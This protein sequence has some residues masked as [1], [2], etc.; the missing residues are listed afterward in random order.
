MAVS[1]S[2]RM[3]EPLVTVIN[4]PAADAGLSMAILGDIAHATR[5]TH[6]K[7]PIRPSGVG[8]RPI[9]GYW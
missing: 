1:R 3:A 7:W 4:G 6:F 9:S 2:A 8:E 5:S